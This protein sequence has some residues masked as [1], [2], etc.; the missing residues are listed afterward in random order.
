MRITKKL[1]VLVAVSGLIGILPGNAQGGSQESKGGDVSIDLDAAGLAPPGPPGAMPP[2]PMPGGAGPQAF[3]APLPGMPMMGDVMFMAE[4]P[5]GPDEDILVALGPGG[6]GMGGPGGP[7]GHG[8]M[9]MRRGH[10]SPFADL[11]LTDDQYEKLWAIK[12]DSAGRSAGKFGEMMAAEM[13]LHD[14]ML[15]PEIDRTKIMALQG[16]VNAIKTELSNER[17]ENKIAAMNVLTAEQRKDLRR[18]MLQRMSGGWGGRGGGMSGH[19]GGGHG[20]P[21]GGCPKK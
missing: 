19:G 11:N 12:R 20:C 4:M 9:M 3:V 2:P 1:A 5:D 18:N 14:L 10:G 6:P 7:G 16:R 15:Q 13:Q 8:G 17:L 21:V